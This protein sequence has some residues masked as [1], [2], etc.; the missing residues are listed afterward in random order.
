MAL[1][2]IVFTAVE[3]HRKH[4]PE[5][6]LV[7]PLCAIFSSPPRPHPSN[8]FSNIFIWSESLDLNVLN[9][10]FFGFII[11]HIKKPKL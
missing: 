7:Q 5:L 3:T 11:K 8:S 9:L 10:L 6:A 2:S 1:V 4:V